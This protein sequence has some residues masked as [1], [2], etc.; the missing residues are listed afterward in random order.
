MAAEPEEVRIAVVHGPNLNLL[1]QREPE[2]YG[3]T[4]L[5][6]IDERLRTEGRAL[7]VDVETFQSNVEGVLIDYIQEAAA[8]VAG[9]VVNAAGYTHTSVAIADALSGVGRPYVEVHVTNLA[10]R[11][12]FRHTSLLSAKAAGVVAGFGPASS[13]L[14]LMGLVGRLRAGDAAMSGAARTE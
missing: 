11:E 5:T 7:G 14:G 10:A 13:S 1:G 9:F 2:L 8:R 3:A 6:A 4:T 12:S